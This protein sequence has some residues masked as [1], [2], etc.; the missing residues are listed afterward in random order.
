VL[1]HVTALAPGREEPF[2][3]LLAVEP[4]YAHNSNQTTD[5]R[6]RKRYVECF[7]LAGNAARTS[8]VFG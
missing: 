5:H 6:S 4:S 2:M 3:C 7:D 8:Q 1:D